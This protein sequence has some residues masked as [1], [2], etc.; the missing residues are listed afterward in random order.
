MTERARVYE[1]IR[2]LKRQGFDVSGIDIDRLGDLSKVTAGDIVVKAKTTKKTTKGGRLKKRYYSYAKT[3]ESYGIEAP[4]KP[5]KFTV[6]KANVSHISEMQQMAKKADKYYREHP[7]EREAVRR[8]R[9]TELGEK[10]A[11]GDTIDNFESFLANW[12]NPIGYPQDE[13]RDL[14]ESEYEA[15]S[16]AFY[17]ALAEYGEEYVAEILAQ[18]ATKI[19]EIMDVLNNYNGEYPMGFAEDLQ[20]MF[21]GRNI[22]MDEAE[23]HDYGQGAIEDE[24]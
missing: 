7:Q 20:A 24:E 15:V 21:E 19:A 8:E 9:F 13:L 10:Y 16:N 14:F 17:S 4:E 23:S 12:V 1:I 3:L 22:G 18:N 11:T 5:T 6:S 2:G